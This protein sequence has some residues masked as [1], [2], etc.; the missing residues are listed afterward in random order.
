MKTAYHEIVNVNSIGARENPFLLHDILRKADEE[1]LTPSVQNK[2]RVLFLGI[3]VQQDFMEQG[4]LGVPGAHGDV[5]RMT[6]FLYENM[7][8]I[9]NI[10]VSLDTHTPHQIFHPCWW[11]DEAGRHP[12]PG[13][14]ITRND[15]D[16]GR[17]R[18]IISP[19]ASRDYVEHLEQE[20]R[21]TLIVWPYHCLQGTF[22]A[23]L[24]NQFANMV[25]FHSVAKKAVTM[26][27]VK[28]TDPLSEM[29]GIYRPEY[30]ANNYI[31]L[32]AL[33]RLEQYDKIVI[34]GEAKSHCVLESIRQ[35]L[36]HYRKRP[37][38]TGKVYILE[39]CMSSIPGFEDGTDQAFEDFRKTYSV[40]LVKSTDGFLQGNP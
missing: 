31:N 9:S 40:N 1:N 25:Y 35:I 29:Y 12:A 39:D 24:E 22:G 4:A 18:A 11:I 37:E 27:M 6:G 30:D 5:E 13:T 2:E 20:G 10:A 7:D 19:V 33:N 15:L 28:G 21:K 16:C 14:P 34:A 32:E 3:D 26:R 23:A 17:Y 36:Q 8:R 38:I